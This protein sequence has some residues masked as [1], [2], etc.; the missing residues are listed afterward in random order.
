MTFLQENSATM[1]QIDEEYLFNKLCSASIV[2]KYYQI[3]FAFDIET[4]SFRIDNEKRATMYLWQIGILLDNQYYIYGRTWDEWESLIRKLRRRLSLNTNKLIIYVHNLSYEFQWIYKHIWF[5]KIFARKSRHP[6]YCES[7]TIIFKCSYFLSNYSLRSLAKNRGYTEKENLDYS[8]LRTSVTP[9][10]PEEL[11]Y[12]LIDT[13][14][15]CEYIRDEIKRNELI[16][17]I[18]LTST[19]YARR[20]CY[21]YISQHENIYNYQKWLRSILP[22]DKSLFELLHTGYTGAF[23]HANYKHVHITLENI[24]CI[25]YSSS[26]P[27]V[28]C[29]KRFPMRFHKVNPTR[30]KLFAGKAMIMLITFKNLMATTNHSILS[31]HKCS[32]KGDKIIDNGRIRKADELT[33]V[34]TDLDYDIATKFYSFSEYEIKELWIANY[35][36]LPKNLILAILQ[37]YS[38]KTKLKGVKGKEEV[39]L[40]SKELINSVY[41]MSVTNP[42]NDETIFID[43]EWSYEEVDIDE[44]LAKYASNRKIF[45]AYQWGVWVTAWA[46]WEL[47]NTVYKINDDVIYCDTDS[48]KYLN[49]HDDIIE[50]DN[51]RI[52]NENHIIISK[53]NIS[54]SLYFP[55]TI[56]GKVK[57]L[58]IWDKEEDYKYFKTLGAKRY[59]FSYKEYNPEPNCDELDKINF[60]ITVAGL[61][62]KNGKRAILALA[63]KENKSPFDVFSYIP[64]NPVIISKEESGKMCFTYLSKPFTAEV[65]DYLGNK[66][67]V[68]EM[69]YV[70]SEPIPFEFKTETIEDYLTLIG[71][72]NSETNM[73]GH[74]KQSRL[75]RKVYGKEKVL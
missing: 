25:D 7:N 13:K 51:K 46:R 42:L 23:T 33:T 56:K 55:K 38:D 44:G 27:A 3:P 75:R 1:T 36:Y 19:G 39:Y 74:F 69:S 60:F 43:D 53:L 18:P 4:S 52:L 21:D 12:G 62:K 14:I 2:E 8:L 9:L 16:Q 65:T 59:C 63:E 26:Y 28:M 22:L 40:R 45:T 20:Y 11:H 67:I 6:I 29:R 24:S 57:P 68:H 10:T 58:G 72:L 70:N 71:V 41:G 49:N 66:T 61:A 73:G 37:L 50:E 64:D 30:F 48:I 31:S 32:I 5:T 15:I 35:E 17:N 47:L 54:E 34:L